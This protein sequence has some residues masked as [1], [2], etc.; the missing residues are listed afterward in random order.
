[1]R[2]TVLHTLIAERAASLGIDFLWQT[3]GDRCFSK[4]QF[5]LETAKISARWIIGADGGEFASAALGRARR[6]SQERLP[7]RISAA[8]SRRALDRSHGIALGPARARST[9]PRFPRIRSALR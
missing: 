1:M 3:A 7:L 4:M 8:L 6:V 9:S 5:T 2:R